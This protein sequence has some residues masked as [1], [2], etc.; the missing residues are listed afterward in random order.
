M[1]GDELLP[2]ALGRRGEVDVDEAV[3][4][5]VQVGLEGEHRLLVGHVLVLGVKV[6]DE[7][8]PGQEA[9]WRRVLG[10]RY[11]AT[12]GS[13]RRVSGGT[14]FS[15]PQSFEKYFNIKDDPLKQCTTT[16]AFLCCGVCLCSVCITYSTWGTPAAINLLSG[17]Q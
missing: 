14:G 12:T 11:R 5:R 7:L 17:G 10:S 1:L 16:F 2:A 13:I 6:V 4:R 3:A 15:F 9:S 8:Y